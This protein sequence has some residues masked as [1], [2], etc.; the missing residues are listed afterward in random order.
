[1]PF[2]S[3]G[4]SDPLVKGILATG[5]TAPTQIQAEAI[6][7]AIEGRDIIACAQTGTG[8]TAA[9]VL[10]ILNRLCH[11]PRSKKP[12]IKA[13]ILTP[14]REL[15]VQI[16]TAL[17]GYGRFTQIKS[18]TVYGGVSIQTQLKALQKGVDIVVAT[19]GRLMDHMNRKSLDLRSIEV[20]VLDEA[21]RMFDMG[22]I[23]DVRK[24]V[25]TMPKKR[26]TLLFSA[27]MSD[28]IKALTTSIQV[29]PKI[30]VVGQQRNPIETIT[31]HVYHVKAEQKTDLLVHM[32]N[33]GE[34]NSV[35][36]FSRTKRGADKIAR[37]LDHAGVKTVTVHSDKS[38]SQRM[39]A[40][41]GFRAGKFQVMVATDVAA[42]GIDISGISHVVNFDVPAYAEDYIH[43]IGRTGRAEA[44]GDAITF[45]S[46]DEKDYIKK[47]ERFIS[48][49]FKF[50][51]Y[52]GFDYA[53]FTP[54]TSEAGIKSYALP[55]MAWSGKKGGGGGGRKSFG[56]GR[57]GGGAGGASRRP[58]ARRK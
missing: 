49:K 41:E 18:L 4:L 33:D 36:V 29:D 31:Q 3:L 32:L 23:N 11:E 42:R 45:V 28:D 52:P 5:Y 10:P 43:R 37:R 39:K 50:E 2:K 46:D 9:F 7:A 6:P 40:M 54:A 1:M 14:T 13:L 24:I 44:T 48:K 47:I 57:P 30:I 53:G 8:K 17:K 22:F 27:T 25:G 34:M 16:E 51:T 55:K 21:D 12:V 58:G 35:L 15:A 20:L 19:P 56:G 26:Q 38:Q